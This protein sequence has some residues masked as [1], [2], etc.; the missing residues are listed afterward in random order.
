MVQIVLRED[1]SRGQRVAG[2]VVEI[3]DDQYGT[4]R[5]YQIASGSTIGNQRIVH[6][7]YAYLSDVVHS[8]RR[9]AA[10]QR[11]LDGMQANPGGLT[12]S[13]WRVRVTAKAGPTQHQASAFRS[14]ELYNPQ[15]GGSGQCFTLGSP[16]VCV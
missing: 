14:I 2:F 12:G 8:S 11:Q 5:W 10:R 15:S 6:S 16:T 7:P 4:L 13:K 1:L 9:V 3:W